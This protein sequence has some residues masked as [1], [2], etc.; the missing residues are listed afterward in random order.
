MSRQHGFSLIE[1][2]TVVAIILIIA[3]IAVP[4]LIRSRMAANEASA[5]SS[6]R[7]IGD[8]NVLYFSLFNVGFAGELAHLGPPSGGGGGRGRGRGRGGCAT[9][10]PQCADLIDMVISGVNPNTD[11]PVKNGYSFEY[12]AD[13]DDPTPA[14]P[15]GTYSVVA[16]PTAAGS[17]GVST[18]CRDYTNVILK[19]TSGSQTDADDEGCAEDWPTGGTITP[20]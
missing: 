4:N 14:E 1:L 17:S 7:T 5:A 6:L 8:A 9:F 20:L 12:E 11:E 19:D 15:N 18:F 2:L 10:S 13:E 3:A 16:T